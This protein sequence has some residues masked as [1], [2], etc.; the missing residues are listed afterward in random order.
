MFVE[1]QVSMKEKVKSN[2]LFNGGGE[3]ML[4]DDTPD[5]NRTLKTP[6]YLFTTLYNP[7]AGS[8]DLAYL[9]VTRYTQGVDHETRPS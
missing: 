7:V 5:F 4:Y 9:N 2:Y 3:I 8:I 6:Q 1:G